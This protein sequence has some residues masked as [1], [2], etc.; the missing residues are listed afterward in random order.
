MP[1]QVFTYIPNFYHRLVHPY[2]SEPQKRTV[3]MMNVEND[4]GS[5]QPVMAES[6]LGHIH[7]G[8]K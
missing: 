1:N 6:R 4:K 8:R 3:P 2:Q 5:K 7:E